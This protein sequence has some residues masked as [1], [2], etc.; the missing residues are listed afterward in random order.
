MVWLIIDW[1]AAAF[2]PLRIE[3]SNV[4]LMTSPEVVAA[5]VA[6][7]TIGPLLPPNEL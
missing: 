4:G 6:V 2:G 3:L 5:V 1:I 7:F